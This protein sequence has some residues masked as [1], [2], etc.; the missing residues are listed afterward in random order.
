MGESDNKDVDVDDDWITGA[1]LGGG[2]FGQLT[3]SKCALRVLAMEVESE[4]NEDQ[5]SVDGEEVVRLSMFQI[6]EGCE[7]LLTNLW[8]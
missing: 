4:L 6:T 5:L 7:F 2:A 8:K 3:D 1:M